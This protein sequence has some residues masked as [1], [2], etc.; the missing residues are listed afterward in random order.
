MENKDVLTYVDQAIENLEKANSIDLNGFP[1]WYE[2]DKVFKAM[3]SHKKGEHNKYS[4]FIEVSDLETSAKHHIKRAIYSYFNLDNEK[5]RSEE[6]A[7]STL[8]KFKESEDIRYLIKAF[9][10]LSLFDD[11]DACI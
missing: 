10:E 2:I 11:G 7:V 8:K 6:N 9:W 3:E 4:D 5:N 1:Y